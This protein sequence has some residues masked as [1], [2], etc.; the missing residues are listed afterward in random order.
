[1]LA[2]DGVLA[3]LGITDAGELRI[4]GDPQPAVLATPLAV[5]DCTVASVAACLAAAAELSLARTG[6][7]PVVSVST[8]HIAAAVRS[9]VWLRD[10]AGRGLGGFAPLS[11]LWRADDGWVRTH[12]NYPWHRSALLPLASPGALRHPGCGSWT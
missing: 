1:M 12:A 7:R 5:A 6:R 11:R 4:T 3:G 9:E 2:L 8:G 10:A